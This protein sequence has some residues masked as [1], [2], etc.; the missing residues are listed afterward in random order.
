MPRTK[1]VP[2]RL[3]PEERDRLAR[4]AKEHHVSLSDYI[5]RLALNR[6]MPP[7][8]QPE[9]NRETYRE[10]SRIGNNLNQLT[11]AL[12]SGVLQGVD[13]GLLQD[14]RNLVKQVGLQA[15]GAS[16]K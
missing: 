10:L 15:L 12:N 6:Q 3:S 9:I 13:L 5:R 11:R 2:V 8:A 4:L 16:A 14:I 1:V 7:A